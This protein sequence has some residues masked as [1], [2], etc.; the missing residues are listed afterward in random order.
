MSKKNYK[1]AQYKAATSVRDFTKTKIC[2]V[3]KIE[4]S[5][6]SFPPQATKKDGSANICYTCKSN[7]ELLNNNP[8]A[9]W[10]RRSCI[11][12]RYKNGKVTSQELSDLF[13][14]QNHKCF[15]CD[16][17]LNQNNIGMDHKTP[18]SGGG[19]TIITNIVLCCRD[20]NNLKL[21]KTDVE[22]NAFL[23]KYI[24]R[25][26]NKLIRTEGSEEIAESGAE[27]SGKETISHQESETSQTG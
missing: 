21:D 4:K 14:K 18:I 11:L 20:C 3:C 5:L 19:L 10:W 8:Q 2:R 1:A 9:Y 24:I 12:S 16:V 15:Y 23:K 22:F 17:E 6:K 25:I 26:F 27:H 7:Q 13:T